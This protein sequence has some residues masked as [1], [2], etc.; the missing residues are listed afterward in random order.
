MPVEDEC[1]QWRFGISRWW[2]KF[3]DDGFEELVD[4]GAELRGYRYRLERV[5]PEV[6]IDLLA[7]AID[8]GRGQI[9]LV[10][11]RKQREVVLHRDVQVR[12]RLGFDTLGRID[13]DEG[14]VAGHERAAHLVG[15]VHVAGRVDEVQ[16]VLVSVFRVVE[17][18]DGVA[19]D[20]DPALALD[21]HGV[22]DLVPELAGPR[23][24]HTSG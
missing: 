1:L 18:G 9:D 23:H 24:L 17:K 21:V 15:K 13:Q 4:P 20:R 5:E 22:Q 16:L 19:L 11:D 12:E 14:P 3:F 10:D 2:R 7:D 6:G 8:V